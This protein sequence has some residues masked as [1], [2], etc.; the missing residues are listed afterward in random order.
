VYFDVSTQATNLVPTAWYATN[1]MNIVWQ[2]ATS[3]FSWSRS[4]TTY[5]VWCNQVPPPAFYT[6]KVNVA[7]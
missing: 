7:P 4:N 2:P 3:G 6:I 1:L 5:R